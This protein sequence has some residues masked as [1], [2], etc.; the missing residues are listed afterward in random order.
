VFGTLL[1]AVLALLLATPLAASVALFI[2]HYAPRTLA[3]SL[4]WN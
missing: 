2:T 4:G 3:Q 1:S